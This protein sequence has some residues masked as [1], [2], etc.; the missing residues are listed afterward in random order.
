MSYQ[1]CAPAK[2]AIGTPRDLLKASTRVTVQPEERRVLDKTVDGGVD[3]LAHR[4]HFPACLGDS[5]GFPTGRI[6][7][8]VGLRKNVGALEHSVGRRREINPVC[9]RSGNREICNCRGCRVRICDLGPIRASRRVLEPTINTR[10]GCRKHEAGVRR[11]DHDS[12]D[13]AGIEVFS[14]QRESSS[15][16]R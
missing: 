15:A 1:P 16:I 7:L 3:I 8:P 6:R 9:A 4:K 2:S 12:K 11:I 10:R 5:G 14:F 13:F